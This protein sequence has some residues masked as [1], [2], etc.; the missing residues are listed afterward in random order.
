MWFSLHTGGCTHRFEAAEEFAVET[1]TG[2]RDMTQNIAI[3]ARLLQSLRTIAHLT[4][5]PF[6]SQTMLLL[7]IRNF[8]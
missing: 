5:F 8:T 2:V 6:L 1:R 3:G 7:C 4:S